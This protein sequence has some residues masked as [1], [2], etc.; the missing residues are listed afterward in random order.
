M[1]IIFGIAG[2]GYGHA[3]RSKP[4]IDYLS[5]SHEVK[6]FTGGKA[7]EYLSRYYPITK[8]TSFR[9]A[10][11]NNTVSTISSAI[12]N[13]FKIPGA[14]ISLLKTIVAFW[15]FK[16]QLVI[17]D[18]E[19]FTNWTA[20]I[21]WVPIVHINNGEIFRCGHIET[22]KKPYLSFLKALFFSAVINPQKTHSLIPSFFHVKTKHNTK[23]VFP[24][25]RNE[26]KEL[27][28]TEGDYI[29]VYQTSE[30]NKKLL[31]TLQ[32]VEQNFVIYGFERNKI[33]KN[34]WLK[35]FNEK[36]FFKDLENCKA[37]IT[38]GGFSLMSESIYLKK[39]VLSCP[40]RKQFEQEVNAHYLEKIGC[41][42]S[43]KE[44]TVEEIL[45]FVENLVNYKE[46]L[47]KFKWKENFFEEL[48]KIV[49]SVS[50]K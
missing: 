19:L 50:P 43:V 40:V 28:P 2:E 46:E 34:L 23:L 21:F 6:I 13:L 11:K 1:R 5:K 41:G 42:R 18:F 47:R 32:E 49:K 14:F 9:L 7:L 8:V 4:V 26:V 29:L 33:Q 44:I 39:P 15:K 35:R 45:K 36:E 38:N 25:L 3:T 17:N 31:E 16:P 22:P 12:L 20:N 48:D 37:V 30:N 27:V 10:Y 24:P